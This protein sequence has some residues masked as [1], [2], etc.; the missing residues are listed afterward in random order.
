[1]NWSNIET[2]WND[3]KANAKQ[4]WDKLSDE[5]ITDTLGNVRT[6]TYEPTFNRATSIT[7]P[8]GTVSTLTYDDRGNV[9]TVTNATNATT[10]FTYDST[11][12]LLSMTDALGHVYSFDYD[13]F[14]Q[15]IKSK[16]Y[17]NAP[18]GLY[19]PGD[20]GFPG[21]KGFN[22]QW[23]RFS[24]RLGMA[25]DLTGDAKTAVHASAGLYHNPHVN[26]NGMDAMARNPPAQNTPSIP[27]CSR[28]RNT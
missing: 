4:Q 6:F 2:G 26:A 20:A 10:T 23:K 9:L 5:Q 21:N 15:G 14:H 3:F 7:D 27:T 16:V 1:M 17:P 22:N 25:W 8:L 24:P 12:L 13:R 11:G 18:A 19:Y 28:S